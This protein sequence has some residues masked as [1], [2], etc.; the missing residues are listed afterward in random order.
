M[1]LLYY[2]VF[3]HLLTILVLL[4]YI[5]RKPD[6]LILS[7]ADMIAH[8]SGKC[9][10]LDRLLVKLKAKGHRAVIFSQ[11][12]RHLDIID[13]LL[14]MRGYKF[15]RLDGSTF[16]HT[17]NFCCCCVLLHS[18]LF[19]FSLSSVALLCTAIACASGGQ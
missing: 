13:D 19:F 2:Y 5:G 17:H 7:E 14:R 8:A 16:L 10:V 3:S 18:F 6:D 4:V 9:E 1:Y 15:C 11:F 12:T